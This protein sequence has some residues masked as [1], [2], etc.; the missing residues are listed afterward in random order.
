MG[1]FITGSLNEREMN[2]FVS[3][4]NNAGD[5]SVVGRFSVSMLRKLWRIGH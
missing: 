5:G 3:D 4:L 2:L 1:P